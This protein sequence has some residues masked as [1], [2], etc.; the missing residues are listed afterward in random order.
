MFD[1][2][3]DYWRM[4]S[5]LYQA[6]YLVRLALHCTPLSAATSNCEQLFSEYAFIQTG[7]QN[8]LGAKKV[9]MISIIRRNLAAVLE[10]DGLGLR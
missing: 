9:K 1:K 7:I 10:R 8:R 4:V 5:N 6:T 2:P 3:E